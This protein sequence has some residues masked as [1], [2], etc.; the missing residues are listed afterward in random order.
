MKIIIVLMVKPMFIGTDK[1]RSSDV[2][3]VLGARG[4]YIH[5]LPE[6]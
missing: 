4:Q 1:T 3:Q 5:S 6:G 2:P